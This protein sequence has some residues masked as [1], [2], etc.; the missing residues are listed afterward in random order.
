MDKQLLSSA[1]A[2]TILIACCTG[3]LHSCRG[4]KR[5]QKENMDYASVLAK[6]VKRVATRCW[7]MKGKM[8]I[9]KHSEVN[10]RD[11]VGTIC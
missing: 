2:A 7:C 5:R 10:G 1:S 4:D 11:Y 8:K 9:L 6:P 3:N